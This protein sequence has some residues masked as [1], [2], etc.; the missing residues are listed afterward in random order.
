M[1]AKRD[2]RYQAFLAK[3]YICFKLETKKAEDF[4]S[5]FCIQVTKN[6]IFLAELI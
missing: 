4:S 6:Y 2:V 1:P 5:A 3:P